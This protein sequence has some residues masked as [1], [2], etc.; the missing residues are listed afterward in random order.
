MINTTYKNII[1]NYVGKL[2]GFI[3]IFLFIRIYID[4]LGLQSY[5]IISFYSTVLGILA[6]A[7]S[8]LTA[9][10]SREMAKKSDL[11][12]KANLLYTFERIYIIICVL[13]ILIVL[14]LSDY[15]SRNFLK[16][17]VYSESQISYY[18]KLI[19]I[20][21]GLQL[22]SSLYEGGLMGLQKQ[23]LTNKIKICWGAFRSGLVILPLYFIPKLELYF[24]WQIISNFLLLIIIRKYLWDELKNS[25]NNYFSK[26][27]LRKIWKYALGMMLI[28]LVSSINIQI[29]KII[30]SKLLDLKL[31]GYYSLAT[32]ISQVPFL[33]V[34]PLMAAVFPLFT[35]SVSS[36]N[37]NLTKEHFHKYSYIISLVSAGVAFSIFFYAKDLIY[38]WTGDQSISASID[39]SVKILVVG[40]LFLCIQLSPFY[41]ALANGYTKINIISGTIC[42]AFIV[43]M[44]YYSIH[45]NGLNGASLPWL[46]INVFSFF[47]IGTVILKKFL[48]T[49]LFK[50]L[51]LDVFVPLTTAFVISFIVYHST[52]YFK[53]PFYSIL[54]CGFIFITSA[55]V[56]ILIYNRLNSESPLFRI[57]I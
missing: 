14:V 10:L 32:T 5:A 12:D 8:G 55:F 37:L 33:V 42:V 40:G 48:R 41:L 28:G 24:I 18:I 56:N 50:W 6:F 43:P 29:D 57:K 23:V 2:W 15:I 13:I 49:E 19:G 45:K 35:N 38:V 54:K 22:F 31:F 21:I 51:F 4:I 34:S 25:Q 47:L 3:S 27:L 17:D 9:T 26:E 11:N 44:M 20:G 16:S 52:T 36:N 46:F 53:V 30:T 39:F 1:A 7:D